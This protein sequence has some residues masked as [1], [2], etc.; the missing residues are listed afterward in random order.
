M[1]MIMTMMSSLVILCT[2]DRGPHERCE[3]SIL[4]KSLILHFV[5]CRLEYD[6]LL[7]GHTSSEEDGER[8]PSFKVGE[9][10]PLL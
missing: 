4:M 9:F 10:I 5:H 7:G 6:S 2:A 1:I 8:V 3:G